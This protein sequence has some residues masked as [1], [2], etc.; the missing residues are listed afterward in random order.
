[1]QL[2][3]DTNGLVV[4]QRKRCFQVIGKGK[5]RLIS[6]EKV[7]SIAVIA[8]CLLS[9]AAI[10]LAVEHGIPIFFFGPTGDVEGKLWSPYFVGMASLRRAQALWLESPDC[11]PWAVG[12]AKKKTL[13]QAG[14]LRELL[15]THDSPEDL[16]PHLALLETQGAGF[17]HPED[18]PDDP[19]ALRQRL[20]GL[21]GAAAKGYWAALSAAA[22]VAWRF[23][24]RS[25]RPA[26]DPFNAALNYLYGMLY[27]VVERAVFAAGL[28]PY[29]GVLHAE[30]YDRPALTYD[31]I[32]PFRPWVDALL[33]RLCQENALDPRH[34][35][36][37]D[38]GW[39]VGKPGKAVLIPRF[40]DFLFEERTEDGERRSVRNHIHAFADALAD[41]LRDW[42]AARKKG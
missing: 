23:E 39:R 6:P 7:T 10:R 1:M 27:P 4:K 37:H 25:R 31:L 36:T 29:M 18:L 2:V 41:L 9:A 3:L 21:E 20:L 8:E 14:H 13:R 26:Q 28:D 12:L 30:E 35:D 40:N 22:P 32:E 17:S 11:R 16:A 38:G 33:L 42:Y 5:Q 19:E 24:G 34:F 15:E